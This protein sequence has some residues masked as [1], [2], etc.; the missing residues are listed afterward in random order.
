MKEEKVNNK[1]YDTDQGDEKINKIRN[2]TT[3]A[4][5]VFV[6]FFTP[7]SGSSW[8]TDICEQSKILSRPDECFNPNFTPEMTRAFGARN[9]T[10]YVECLKRRR[11]TYGTFGCQLTYYQLSATFG[12]EERFMDY[13]H[14]SNFF[15]LTRKDIVSQAVS[16][17][18]MVSTS[19]T[20]APAHDQIEIDKS[21]ASYEYNRADIRKWADHI[22]NAERATEMLFEK[23]LIN[24]HRMYYEDITRAGSDATIELIA[25]KIGVSKTTHVGV[26]SKHRKISTPKNIEYAERFL[27]EETEFVNKIYEDRQRYLK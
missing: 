27:K 14:G 20:H 24:P 12:S 8:L 23:Y 10:E 26:K 21:D 18:K 17:A 7:R 11:N 5:N 9:L 4:S 6:V 15:W 2:N 3:E 19:I 22:R 13:F 1:V 25:D 16:L